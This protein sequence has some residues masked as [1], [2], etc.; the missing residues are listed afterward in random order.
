MGAPWISQISGGDA[1]TATEQQQQ[2]SWRVG[3]RLFCFLRWEGEKKD[4]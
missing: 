4:G 1:F 2:R 3:V